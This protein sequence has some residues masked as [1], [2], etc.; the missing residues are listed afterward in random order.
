[1]APK[2]LHSIQYT[3]TRGALRKR[4]SLWRDLKSLWRDSKSLWR[5]QNPH[6]LNCL[7]EIYQVV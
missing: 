1:M 4:K 7:L 2:I 5:I 3:R 6:Y